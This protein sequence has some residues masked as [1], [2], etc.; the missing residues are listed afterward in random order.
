M[1]R[2][3]GEDLLVALSRGAEIARFSGQARQH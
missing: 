2:S 3:G 1:T